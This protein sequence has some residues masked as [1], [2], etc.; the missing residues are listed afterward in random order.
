MSSSRCAPSSSLACQR[1]FASSSQSLILWCFSFH[2]VCRGKLSLFLFL[3]G[4]SG[5]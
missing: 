1:S 5:F 3:F 2:R 4:F